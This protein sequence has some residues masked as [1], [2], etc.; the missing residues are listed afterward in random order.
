MGEVAVT[1][2]INQVALT[3]TEFV[4]R[5]PGLDFAFVIL[6][7]YGLYRLIKAQKDSKKKSSSEKIPPCCQ[8]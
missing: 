4:R 8:K 5:I 7:G 6:A 2:Q 1:K 3:V